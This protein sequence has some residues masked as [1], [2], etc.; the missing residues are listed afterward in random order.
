VANPHLGEVEFESGGV[1]YT[2]RFDINTICEVD[3]ALG[4]DFIDR[5]MSQ[6]KASRRQMRT[7]FWIALRQNHPEIDNETKA[8]ALVNFGQMMALL[9]KAI[10]AS[11]PEADGSAAANGTANP[12]PAGRTGPE[13]GKPGAGA[14]STPTRSGDKRRAQSN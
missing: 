13:S 3:E 12:L 7:L 8:G 6:N 9:A 2:L 5:V 11:Q 10:L 14:D 1:R 4:D